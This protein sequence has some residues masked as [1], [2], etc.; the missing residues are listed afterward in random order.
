MMRGKRLERQDAVC[1]SNRCTISE[2]AARD[3]EYRSSLCK[4]KTKD[5]ARTRLIEIGNEIEINIGM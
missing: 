2:A 4:K 1:K 5:E 3:Y